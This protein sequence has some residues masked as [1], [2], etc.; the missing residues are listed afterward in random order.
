MLRWLFLLNALAAVG[1]AIGLV[2]VPGLLADLAM[3]P[4]S[5]SWARYLMPIYLALAAV[6][7]VAYRRPNASTGIGWALVIV[8]A[9]LAVSHVVNMALGDE[10]IGPPTVGLLVFDAVMVIAL[11]AALIAAKGIPDAQRGV[12]Q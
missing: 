10:P 9:G 6:S 3:A 8:W 5:V 1:Y 11:T 4:E 7:W 2:V 12:E